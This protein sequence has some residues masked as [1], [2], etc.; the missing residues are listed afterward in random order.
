MINSLIP[1]LESKDLSA[2]KDFYTSTLKFS[3]ENFSADMGW[4]SLKKDAA[5]VMFSSPNE[6]R[7][8]PEPIMSGSLYFN[9]ENVDELWNEL[10]DKVKVC[11][12]I[13]NFEYG[14]REFAIFDNNGYV[15]QF[16]EEIV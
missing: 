6:H 10:K 14:M 1:M 12:P 5:S 15:L 13:E 7:N 9:T 2:T 4:L 8:I 11:Y 3:A 16:G